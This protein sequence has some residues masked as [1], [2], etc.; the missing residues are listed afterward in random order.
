[1]SKWFKVCIEVPESKLGTIVQ[2]LLPEGRNLQLSEVSGAPI[3]RRSADLGSLSS[4]KK[5]PRGDHNLS[6]QAIALNELST[7][8]KSL[9]QIGKAM[10][11]HGWKRTSASP[12][13]YTLKKAGK[14]RIVARGMYEKV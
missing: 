14:V 7:G 9:K 1:M 3:K 12:A 2:L 13:L 6:P 5:P 8:H 4:I 11:A 10:A